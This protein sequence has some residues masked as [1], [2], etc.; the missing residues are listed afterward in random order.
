MEERADIEIDPQI[1]AALQARREQGQRWVKWIVGAALL[2][3]VWG[4]VT[5]GSRNSEEGGTVADTGNPVVAP[6]LQPLPPPPSTTMA[7]AVETAGDVF[8]DVSQPAG[9]V[10]H[11][12]AGGGPKGPTTGGAPPTPLDIP[13][14][15]APRSKKPPTAR[16]PSTP[17]NQ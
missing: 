13:P 1:L 9:S 8:E 7:E 5:V 6:P 16:F 10:V 12:G 4:I 3:L 14:P 15:S 11:G 17:D 2:L